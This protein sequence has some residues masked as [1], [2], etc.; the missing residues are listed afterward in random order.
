MGSKIIFE[1]L[2]KDIDYIETLPVFLISKIRSQSKFI[3]RDGILDGDLNRAMDNFSLS[4]YRAT[5]YF[6]R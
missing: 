6:V 5:H 1:Y 4:G 3:L 2:N